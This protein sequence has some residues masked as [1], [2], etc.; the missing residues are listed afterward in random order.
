MS[1]QMRNRAPRGANWRTSESG[2]IRFNRDFSRLGVGRIARSSRTTDVKEFQRRNDILTKLA[3]SAQ[4]DVL[5]AFRDGQITIEQLV[6]ADR[7]QRLKS[8]D[9]LGMLALRRPLWD[10]IADT[11]PLMGASE[12]TRKRYQVSLDALHKKAGPELGDLANI[13]DLERVAWRELRERW[14]RSPSDWNHLRRAISTFLSNLLGDKFH[15]FRRAVVNRIP[16]AIERGRVPDVTPDVFWSIVKHVPKPYRASF[17][18]LAATGMRVGEYLACTPFSLRPATF[19]IAV[20]GTKTASSAE[21]IAVH[22]RLWPYVVAAVPAPLKYKALRRHWRA[23]CTTA[24]VDVRIHDL[25]HCYAQWAVN[26]G[27]PEAKVQTALR[28]KTAV[29]TR[30]YAKTKDKGEVAR[31]VGRVLL[32]AQSTKPAQFAAQ[33]GNRGR[34]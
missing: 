26:E 11:L 3:E 34:A 18:A 29:T 23:A 21:D 32:K 27:L 28:H 19:S 7:E 14:G 13:R 12:Q 5:R 20:P 8:S 17:V 15:P 30:R 25:R 6:D 2:G 16:I 1:N 24:E 4:I 33:G 22:P 31:A 9:L 10:A